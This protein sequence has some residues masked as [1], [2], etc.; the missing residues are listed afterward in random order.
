MKITL[1]VTLCHLL[2]L[3]PLCKGPKTP[4]RAT[5][6][7]VRTVTVQKAAPVVAAKS[8]PASV[9]AKPQKPAPVVTKAPTPKPAPVVT[10]APEPT[11]SVAPAKKQSSAQPNQEKLLALMEQSLATLETQPQKVA[12]T[13]VAAPKIAALKSECLEEGVYQDLLMTYLQEA[14]EFPEKGEVK[15]RLT[16]SRTGS[17]TAVSVVTASSSK[18]QSYVTASLPTLQFP[19][20]ESHFKGEKSHTF[21]VTLVSR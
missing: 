6:V 1:L 11:K 17:V 3:F 7:T 16:L 19:A 18:N 2:C 13:V 20:F 4:K 12:Q 8:K 21:S 9:G 15:L 10:K 5:H 14:L